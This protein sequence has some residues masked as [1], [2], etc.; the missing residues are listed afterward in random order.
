MDR[1]VIAQRHFQGSFG[2]WEAG[3]HGVTD[4]YFFAVGSWHDVR[5][6]A[7]AAG[8]THLDAYNQVSHRRVIHKLVKI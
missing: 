8:Y 5:R 4:P 3:G 7:K 2:M 6:R 1:V